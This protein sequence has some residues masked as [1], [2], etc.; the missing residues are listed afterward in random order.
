ME[1]SNFSRLAQAIAW[2]T[3]ATIAYLTLAHVGLVYSIYFKLSPWLLNIGMKQ[4]A[5]IEHVVAFALLG[6]IFC[7]AY[8]KRVL[9]ICFIVFGSAIA[10]EVMQTMTPDRHGTLIDAL[11]KISGGAFGIL[12][13]KAALNFWRQRKPAQKTT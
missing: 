2:M 7:C 11:Q 5:A 3:I 6:A 13:A 4:F 9:M 1:I 12:A 8:P 10:L